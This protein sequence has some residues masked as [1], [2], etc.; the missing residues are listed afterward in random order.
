MS[1]QAIIALLVGC[2]MVGAFCVWLGVENAGTI[3]G[4]V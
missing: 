2:L 3:T 4:Q 1:V